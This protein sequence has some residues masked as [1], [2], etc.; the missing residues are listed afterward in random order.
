M[1]APPPAWL[2]G[3]F[4]HPPPCAQPLVVPELGGRASRVGL[5]T[6]AKH[7]LLE[8]TPLFISQRHKPGS[9]W[10]S[11]LSLQQAL[12]LLPSPPDQAPK[13]GLFLLSN[14][15]SGKA[16]TWP[17]TNRRPR[18]GPHDRSVAHV[19][20]LSRMKGKSEDP[21]RDS[22]A[23]SGQQVAVRPSTHRPP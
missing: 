15:S 18:D 14:T 3:A 10:P 5:T 17:S 1:S 23:C 13:P 20:H 8:A 22:I 7:L 21:M 4:P 6:T 19:S 2:P 12:F 16:S 11:L 9:S